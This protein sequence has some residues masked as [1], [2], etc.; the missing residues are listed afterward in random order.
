MTQLL[1]TRQR[2]ISLN[3]PAPTTFNS[4]HNAHLCFPVAVDSMARMPGFDNALEINLVRPAGREERRRR[5]IRVRAMRRTPP[6]LRLVHVELLAVGHSNLHT[7]Y[8]LSLLAKLHVE[9]RTVVRE[10]GAVISHGIRL[11]HRRPIHTA[12]HPPAVETAVATVY[13]TSH[14]ARHHHA[15]PLSS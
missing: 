8:R 1:P 12:T 7:P 11:Q 3:R 6:A 2:L 15:M 5:R 9:L 13:E 10:G 14:P 4:R